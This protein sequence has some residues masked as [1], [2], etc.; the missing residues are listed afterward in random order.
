MAFGPTPISV[1][2]GSPPIKP[3]LRTA[4]NVVE[5]PGIS[6]H[7]FD[8]RLKHYQCKAE[9]SEYF[10]NTAAL[11]FRGFPLLRC[12]PHQIAQRSFVKSQKS[13][14]PAVI[15]SPNLLHND[16]QDAEFDSLWV[17]SKT[18][19]H[20]PASMPTE[21]AASVFCVV[22]LLRLAFQLQQPQ[23]NATTVHENVHCNGENETLEAPLRQSLFESE[24]HIKLTIKWNKSIK[25]Q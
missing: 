15:P 6:I 8:D 25:N 9:C 3:A 18:S 23:A 12:G 22:V 5:R 14:R 17:W 1:H 10:H 2:I 20:I 13:D 21:V 4:E 7:A 24:N 16:N 11:R 19:C